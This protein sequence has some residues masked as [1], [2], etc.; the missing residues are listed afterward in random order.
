MYADL[1]MG[2]GGERPEPPKQ[3]TIAP[4]PFLWV[5]EFYFSFAQGCAKSSLAYWA[6]TSAL[7][8]QMANSQ[9]KRW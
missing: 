5:L 2:G 8:T 4:N 6:L 1:P 3:I 7:A 9:Q